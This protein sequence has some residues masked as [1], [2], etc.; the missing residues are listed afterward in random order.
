M[1]IADRLARIEAKLKPAKRDRLAILVRFVSPGRLDAPL[2]RVWCGG[3]EWLPLAGEAD[4]VFEARATA[5]AEADASGAPQDVV[6]RLFA[7]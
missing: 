4:D 2:R 3:R 1:S 6:L 7:E 5:Q